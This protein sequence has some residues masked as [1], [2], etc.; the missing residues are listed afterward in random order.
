[1]SYKDLKSYQQSATIYDFTVEFC[2]KYINKKSRTHD[3]MVQAARS[4]K[5][6][7]AEGSAEL[8]EKNELYLLGIARASF[9]ELLEDYEDFLRQ[10]RLAQWT[11]DSP[12]AAAVRSLPYKSYTSY[13]T[14]QSYIENPEAAANVA[15]CLIHQTN[16]LLDR[17]IKAL[18][19]KFIKDGG[20]A[21]KLGRA[22]DEEK[23]R[24][25]IGDFYDP[26]PK[27]WRDLLAEFNKN[28]PKE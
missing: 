5:Q 18:E 13:R 9:Q 11:K 3:Q 14:Y 22:R 1:M 6:N 2:D 20:Y 27:D 16:F 8:A 24:Q 23:K 26:H 10:R 19:E 15:L 21:E 25:I 4:G 12:E 17:Q 7:L 28:R